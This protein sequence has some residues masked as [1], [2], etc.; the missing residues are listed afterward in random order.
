MVRCLLEKGADVWCR[1]DRGRT[2]L[3]AAAEEKGGH[4]IIATLLQGANIYSW[5]CMYASLY[6]LNDAKY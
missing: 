4:S 5:L 2:V 3:H 1:D 6:R